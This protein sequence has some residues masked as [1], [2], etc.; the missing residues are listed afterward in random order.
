MNWQPIE[1]CPRDGS[2]FLVWVHAETH[3]ENDEGFPMDADNSY[4]DIGWWR[5][6]TDP[7][8]YGYVDFG[9]Q[10]THHVDEPEYWMPLPPPP[11]WRTASGE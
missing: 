9:G 1:T 2:C 4:A 11:R 3:G 6:G 8:P 5:A 7:V 10:N